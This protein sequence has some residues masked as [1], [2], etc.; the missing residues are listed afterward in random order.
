MPPVARLALVSALLALAACSPKPASYATYHFSSTEKLAKVVEPAGWACSTTD[1]DEQTADSL[2]RYGFANGI[3][4]Q[5]G[6]LIY[7]SDASRAEID[8]KNPITVGKA[9][10]KGGN[11]ALVGDQYKVEDAQKFVGG[12]I[13]LGK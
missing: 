7:A 13:E 10:I 9:R 5:G 4:T 1:D 11:W 2:A 8:A 12:D 3:C 6:L